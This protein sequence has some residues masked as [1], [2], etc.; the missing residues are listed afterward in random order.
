MTIAPVAG[1][2]AAGFQGATTTATDFTG[3]D[4]IV[5][6][7]V[8]YT[9]NPTSNVTDN[10]GNIYSP[11]SKQTG[12]TASAAQLLYCHAPTVSALMRFTPGNANADIHV[13]GFSGSAASPF[14]QQNGNVAGAVTSIQAGS[15]TP[16]ANGELCVVLAGGFNG[17]GVPS[18]GDP[19]Y[20]LIDANAF[21]ASVSFQGGLWYS[22][23][24]TAAAT[25][26]T[27]SWS[28][29][30]GDAEAVIASFKAGAGVTNFPIS[31]AEA[32][33]GGATISAAAASSGSIAETASGASSSAVVLAGM[34]SATEAAAGADTPTAAASFVVAATEA[35]TAPDSL[36]VSAAFSS[37]VTQA[38]A[39]A[40]TSIPTEQVME[41][42]TGADAAFAAAGAA[43]AVIETSAASAAETV[44]GAPPAATVEAAA[45]ADAASVGP[46]S[47]VVT[48]IS[49]GVV[50]V[51]VWTL[52]AVSGVAEA[53]NALDALAGI[54]AGVA[55]IVEASG[56][57]DAPQIATG[58]F[59]TAISEPAGPADSGVSTGGG[60]TTFTVGVIEIAGAFVSATAAGTGATGAVEPAS[61]TDTA[62]PNELA[63]PTGVEAANG[64]DM[65]G[66]TLTGVAQTAETAF[67]SDVPTATGG[68]I[69]SISEAALASEGLAGIRA[70][71]QPTF[72]VEAVFAADLCFGA[73]GFAVTLPPRLPLRVPRDRRS[74]IVP[75]DHRTLGASQ[76]LT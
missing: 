70:S 54:P 20:T 1:A 76:G 44:A 2:H 74:I 23:Q 19:N 3:V 9:G 27:I 51:P 73:R 58:A 72:V 63:V 55:P 53:A 17:S 5:V 40:D 8:S 65:I 34:A 11:L 12:G 47:V 37:S 24:T 33:S 18:S 50:N 75:V 35:A 38:A 7:Q 32:A 26:P 52:G 69:W 25:N 36:S 68:V 30:G 71:M 10:L 57:S 66:A 64:A 16:G 56:A 29:A 59:T 21:V 15:I 61:A 28:G 60:A 6:G 43:A 67:A 13:V 49:L 42:A 22:I 14:D 39:A 41:A 45:G 4:L 46:L 48:A 31:I 62:I